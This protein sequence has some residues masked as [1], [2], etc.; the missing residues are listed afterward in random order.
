[1]VHNCAVHL[2]VEA[3]TLAEVEALLA[4]ISTATKRQP[5]VCFAYTTHAPASLMKRSDRQ[6][7]AVEE[8]FDK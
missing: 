2:A 6:S 7:V 5:G 3:K 1:M 4:K 8:L